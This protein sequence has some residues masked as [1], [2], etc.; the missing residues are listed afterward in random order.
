M[1]SE[2]RLAARLGAVACIGIVLSVGTVSSSAGDWPQI[3]GP[4]RT[5]I[6][7][8][9]E[10]LLDRWP[11]TGP[12]EIWKRP[13]G[14]GYAGVAVVAG[15]LFLFHREGDREVT[16]ALDAESGETLWRAD[17]ATRFWPQ[18]GGGDGPLCVPTV[19]G[20]RVITFGADGMLTCLDVASGR[21]IWQRHTRREFDAAEGYFG[22]GSSPLVIGD[23]VIVNVGGREGAGVVGFRL[24]TGEPIWRATDEPASYAAPTAVMIDDRPHALVVTRYRCLLLDP[25]D[26]TVCW[27]FPFG[28]RGPTV[29]AATPLVFPAPDGGLRLLVTASYGIGSVCAAFHAT[30]VTP[31]WQGVDSLA[32]QY[33]TPIFHDGR[34]TC[35]DGRDDVPPATLKHIDAATGKVLWQEP[36]FGYGTLVAADGKLLAAKTDGEILLLADS[37]NGF[38]VLSRA[39]PLPGPLR[40]LAAL[41]N[42]RLYLRNDTSL[43]CLDVGLPPADQ[44]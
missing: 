18:V 15:R 41:A 22:S 3:L 35:I 30:A 13:V 10:Q 42:G 33:C 2:T 17:H 40:A 43:I 11:D 16:E 8:A 24:D 7:A 37:P 19:A 32:S 20:D 36:N 39:R 6:A 5:G 26:G 34:L 14:S 23:H 1:G 21:Q 25:A 4:N 44:D 12:R 28:M 29:N 38:E 9:D 27:Q 31:I